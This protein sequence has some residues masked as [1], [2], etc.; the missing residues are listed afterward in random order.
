MIQQI[1]KKKGK[2][3]NRTLPAWF[4]IVYSLSGTALSTEELNKCLLNNQ[5]VFVCN[6]LSPDVR[7]DS[8]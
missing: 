1:V 7:E 4:T 5:L 8:L 6:I 2:C 3:H